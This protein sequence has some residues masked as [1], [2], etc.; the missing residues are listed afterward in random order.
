[1]DDRPAQGYVLTIHLAASRISA[2]TADQVVRDLSH[3]SAVRGPT[4]PD[5][6]LVHCTV[7]AISEGDAIRYGAQRTVAALL[8]VGAE[9][10]RVLSVEAC[11]VEHVAV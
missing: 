1:M 6:L 5:N 9:S 10:P 3:L 11:V 4:L 2:E 7:S 8:G